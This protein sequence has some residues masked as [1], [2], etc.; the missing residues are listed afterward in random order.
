MK[1]AHALVEDFHL[2]AG[3][4]R[5]TG[6]HHAGTAATENDHVGGHV[7]LG[8]KFTGG[9]G[10]VCGGHGSGGGRHGGCAEEMAAGKISLAHRYSPFILIANVWQSLHSKRGL[11]CM[12]WHAVQSRWPRCEKWG[13]GFIFSVRLATAS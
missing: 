11:L 13:L 8:G 9:A 12:L 7:P 2:G 4:V 10:G 1:R 6:G 3:V 5:L